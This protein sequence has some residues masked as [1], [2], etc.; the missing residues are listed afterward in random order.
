MKTVTMKD[1]S[2]VKFC[3]E[4]GKALTD[5][6]GGK[7]CAACDTHFVSETKAPA[8]VTPDPAQTATLA[9]GA[10]INALLMKLTEG[11]IKNQQDSAGL[12]ALVQT[13]ATQIKEMTEKFNGLVGRLD[14]VPNRKGMAMEP[15][16]EGFIKI[17]V[18]IGSAMGLKSEAEIAKVFK[19]DVKTGRPSANSLKAFADMHGLKFPNVTKEMNKPDT[20]ENVKEALTLLLTEAFDRELWR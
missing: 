14:Q 20:K 15:D 7:F 17:P 13:Q 11:T 9:P 18:E 5:K 12:A 8:A 19:L 6:D 3:P 16:A 4:C 10:D 1:A 2:G